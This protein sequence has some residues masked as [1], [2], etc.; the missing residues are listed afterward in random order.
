MYGDLPYEAFRGLTPSYFS[1]LIF[2]HCSTSTLPKCFCEL[3][4]ISQSRVMFFFCISEPLHMLFPLPGMTSLFHLHLSCLPLPSWHISTHF[5]GYTSSIFSMKTCPCMP[6]QVVHFLFC[7]IT[8]ISISFCCD[9]YHH[10]TTIV[11]FYVPLQDF[12]L[13]EGKDWVLFISLKKRV[14]SYGINIIKWMKYLMS[15]YMCIYSCNHHPDQ[16]ANN[17]SASS[18]SSVEPGKHFL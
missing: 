10:C 9:S 4:V 2:W 12:E 8:V 18:E 17:I 15:F 3:L 7:P 16:D 14:L 1:S 5:S 6:S 11:Y 13:L